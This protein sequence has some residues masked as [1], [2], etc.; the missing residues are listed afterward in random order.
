MQ[1]REKGPAGIF[2]QA[3]GLLLSNEV[4]RYHGCPEYRYHYLL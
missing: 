4:I 1:N 2:Q 3:T